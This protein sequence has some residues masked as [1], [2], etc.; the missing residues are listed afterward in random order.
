VYLDRT[1]DADDFGYVDIIVKFH[2]TDWHFVAYA[3]CRRTQAKQFG[4][5]RY[6]TAN[7]GGNVVNGNIYIGIAVSAYNSQVNPII[8]CKCLA[9]TA[10]VELGNFLSELPSSATISNAQTR[11]PI[12]ANYN[13]SDMAAVGSSTRPVY[14]DSYGTIKPCTY[15]ISTSTTGT[16]TNTIYLI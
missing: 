9:G 13:G 6:I 10:K 16:D 2:Q 4:Q 8:T 12:F 5:C 7:G 11:F 3:F 14:V 1:T 15:A